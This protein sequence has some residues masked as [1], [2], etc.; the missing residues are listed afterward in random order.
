MSQPRLFE[1]EFEFEPE[2]AGTPV[3][4]GEPN[5]WNYNHVLV[6]LVVGIAV[7]ATWLMVSSIGN[8]RGSLTLTGAEAGQLKPGAAVMLDG[9]QVGEVEQVAIRNGLPIARL[10]VDPEI[11]QE[12]PSTSRLQVGSLNRVLPGNIGVKIVTAEHA[13]PMTGAGWASIHERLA[14]QSIV[15]T[16]TPLGFYVVLFVVVAIAVLL[17][18]LVIKVLK[19]TAFVIALIIVVLHAWHTGKLDETARWGR[20]HLKASQTTEAP[21]R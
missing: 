14:D 3:L 2:P 21:I 10:Q 11:L 19:S 9:K 4:S 13:E 12:V 15:P 1:D 18:G 17:V 6:G 20:E 8:D 7:M 5:L 16:R